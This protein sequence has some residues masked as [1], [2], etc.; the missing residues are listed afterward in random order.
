[1]GNL[2]ICFAGTPEFAAGHLLALLD[3]PHQVIATYT[4]PDRP[5]GRGKKLLPSPTKRVAEQSAIPLFQPTTLRAQEQYNLLEGLCPDVLVVVAYG[6]IL[7]RAILSIPKFG[8]INVHAS[9]LPRWR[10]AAPIERAIL[11]GDKESGITILQMDEGLDTGAILYQQPISIADSDTRQS[12]ED[13]L[14]HAGKG[15]LL[16]TLDNL[17]PLMAGAIQQDN[18]VSTYAEKLQKTEA[19]INWKSPAS[20]IS[21]TIRAGI[22]RFPAYTFLDGDRLRIIE[23]TPKANRF[24][25]PPGTIAELGRN[26][27]VVACSNS[28][29][30]VN[31]VQLPGKNVANVAQ[32]LNA[33]PSLFAPG[34]S[35][36]NSEAQ[37]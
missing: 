24:E 37:S 3:S 29:L 5:S 28:S 11:A 17:E 10:G 1:M 6:L 26:G 35:F 7:P 34:K 18:Q 14:A 13:N 21:R 8:C 16:Y 9:L 15:A 27:F 31:L 20:T 33:R 36:T 19:L 22:G 4:Q 23:A 32:V 12:L 2:R 25:H 30:H